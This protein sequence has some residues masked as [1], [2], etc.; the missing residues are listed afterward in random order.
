MPIFQ[1]LLWLSPAS[2][3][4]DSTFTGAAQ[5]GTL[6]AEPRRANLP[7]VN[8]TAPMGGQTPN[9]HPDAALPG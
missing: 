8:G 3:E 7:G 4:T 1:P 9:K 6:A 2:S 5:Q